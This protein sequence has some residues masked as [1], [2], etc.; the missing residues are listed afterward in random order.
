MLVVLLQYDCSRRCSVCNI[1]ALSVWLIS[2]G[3]RVSVCVSVCVFV[4]AIMI[5][6]CTSSMDILQCWDVILKRIAKVSNCS[7]S[8]RVVVVV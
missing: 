2:N 5:V 6:W 7:Q 1:E 3:I 4:C 8:H